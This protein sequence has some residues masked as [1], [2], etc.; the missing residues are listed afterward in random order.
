MFGWYLTCNVRLSDG[1]IYTCHQA[2]GQRFECCRDVTIGMSLCF[3]CACSGTPEHHGL[4]H[5]IRYALQ[6]EECSGPYEILP[7]VVCMQE[8]IGGRVVS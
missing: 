1:Y 5:N 4:R 6:Q 2:G 8:L 3:T 7:Y